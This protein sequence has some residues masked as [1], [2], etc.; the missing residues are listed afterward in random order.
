MVRK[1]ELIEPHRGDK[2]YIRRNDKGQF[3]NDQVNVGRSIKKDIRQP[4]EHT[5]PPGYGDRGDQKRR[6]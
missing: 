2:R 4:A 3:T 1:R 6:K 5:V